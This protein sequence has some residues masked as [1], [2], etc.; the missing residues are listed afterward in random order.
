MNLVEQNELNGCAPACI[1][2]LTGLHQNKCKKLFPN[3][4]KN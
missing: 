2:M 1:S 3:K 4:S